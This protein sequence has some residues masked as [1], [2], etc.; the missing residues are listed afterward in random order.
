MQQC[1]Q[2][3]V[4]QNLESRHRAKLGRNG[5]RHTS[6][7]NQEI[8]HLLEVTKCRRK[9][10]FKRVCAKQPFHSD[11]EFIIIA[12]PPYI[13][14]L[15]ERCQQADLRWN[16]AGK[17]VAFDTEVVQIAQLSDFRMEHTAQ[18]AGGRIAAQDKNTKHS[19]QS[20][21]KIIN[22]QAPRKQKIKGTD[23]QG[24]QHC[25]MVEFVRQTTREV[26]LAQR[27][28]RMIR[29]YNTARHGQQ[30]THRSER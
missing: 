18:L 9:S 16:G 27:A 13:L 28:I 1:A 7:G 21:T 3:S 10:A 26:V 4:A 29:E 17:F 8:V 15:T 30:L 2:I 12:T 11:V 20:A 24:A 22:G 23:A 14:Q 5:P 6:E 25:Q 19:Q